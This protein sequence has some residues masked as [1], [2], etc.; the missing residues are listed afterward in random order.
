M[1]ISLI[2][3]CYNEAGNV[4]AFFEAVRRAFGASRYHYECIFVDDGSTDG[5]INILKEM[6]QKY[7][8]DVSIIRFSRNFGKEA[9]ILAGLRHMDGDL[10]A[11]IDA[12][13]QQQPGLVL[14]MADFL[15]V[16]EEYDVVAA[17]QEKRIEGRAMAGAKKIF[18]RLINWT[19]DIDFYPGASDFRTFRCCVAQAVISMPEYFRFSKGIFSWVGFATYYMPYMAEERHAGKSK[20]SVQKLIKYAAEGFLSFT[21]FPLKIASYL[22]GMTSIVSIIYMLV[23][24]IRRLF[25]ATDIP[26]YPTIVVLILLLGGIQLLVLGI[27]GEYLGRIYIQGK[28]RPVYIEK[29]YLK[30]STAVDAC[31]VRG[32]NRD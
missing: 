31:P 25:F 30:A 17:Y 29:E 26:G 24:I 11:V 6:Y 28:N 22:G 20:W 23:V 21:T 1:K 3:P 2:V 4:A 13:L 12:D 10:A 15:A 16:H 9:A 18:Y 14:D 32:V 8:D 27:I 19:C 7:T 5:T